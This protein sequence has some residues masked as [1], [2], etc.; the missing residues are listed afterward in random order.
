MRAVTA[1]T[2]GLASQVD[3]TP[4][5]LPGPRVG[6][7]QGRPD[8]PERYPTVRSLPG[9]DR[10]ESLEL[11]SG[12][13]LRCLQGMP[14]RNRECMREHDYQV[15]TRLASTWSGTVVRPWRGPS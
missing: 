9:L 1:R 8:G 5:A 3:A 2:T 15:P 4:E 13:L 11:P 6:Q 7:S 10:P 14:E 12:E